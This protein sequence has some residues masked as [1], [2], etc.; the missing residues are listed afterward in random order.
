MNPRYDA[1]V[2]GS[3]FGGGV[4]ACRLA[5]AGWS[6]CVLERGRRFD[7]GDFPESPEQA[8]W[9]LWHPTVNPGGL[10][11][12]RIMRDVAV[13]TAAGV[14]GGSLVYAN[15]QLRAPD[16]VF[17][18]PWP[19][20]ITRPVLDPWYDLTEE[21]LDPRTTPPQPNLAKVDAFSVMAQ[22]AGRGAERLPL[23][24]HF[25]KDRVNPFS[26]VYQ[27]GCQNLGR[28]VLGCPV[29]AKNTVDL[30][31]LAKAENDGA[32]IYPSHQVERIEAPASPDDD[33]TVGFRD[34]HYRTTGQVSG[35]VLILAAG[36]LGTTRLLLRNR[37]R[38][39]RLSQVLGTRFSGNGDALGMAFQ[40]QAPGTTGA[41]EDIGPTM[42]SYVDYTADRELIV[43]DGGLPQS[44]SFVFQIIQGYNAIRGW[45]RQL[46]RLTHLPWLGLSDRPIHPRELSLSGP[47][48]IVDSFV[49]MIFGRD[50]ANG[51]IR[52]TPFLRRL[53][54]RWSKDA[55]SR[56]F[57]DMERTTNE[58]AGAAEA[59]P[60]FALDAGPLSKFVT[61]HPLGG[62]PMGSD[63]SSGVVDHLGRAYGYE[64]LVITDGS[65]IPTALGVNPSKTI[66]ALAERSVRHL[67]EERGS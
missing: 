22:R 9:A 29:R 14:G 2:V 15:V 48:P 7:R 44:W 57:T 51:R 28:C 45:K 36:V 3:G 25:G 40:P 13:V 43:A 59:T 53:D 17:A 67:I 4:A 61:V 19:A 66:A 11:D 5:A 50:A 18:D 12:I 33:W 58:L 55:S 26:G 27:R 31:Y 62:C 41:R 10:F 16:S 24:V 39:P 37:S 30:T 32:E 56:L 42:T 38:L 34:L 8:P 35:T 6:V 1:I 49:F 20:E 60:F 54:I 46:L 63:D 65:V 64:R 52:L 23:A 21:A 47:K